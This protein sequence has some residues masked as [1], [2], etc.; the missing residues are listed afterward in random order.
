MAKRKRKKQSGVEKNIRT[1]LAI[2]IAL[3]TVFG[4][5]KIYDLDLFPTETPDNKQTEAI[6]VKPNDKL[7]GK[8][9]RISDGDTVVLL[10]SLG[11]HHKIRLDGVDCP[12]TGQDFGTKATNFTKDLCIDKHITVDVVGT[13]QYQRILGVVY[14]DDININEELLKNGL[15]WRYKYNKS[16]RYLELEEDARLRKINIWSMKNPVAPW[17]FRKNN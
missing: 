13:D 15:A 1:I 8:I 4:G 14:V 16:P 11:T 7:N 17:D 12:E 2:I 3:V 9:I 10:D 5:S 6:I